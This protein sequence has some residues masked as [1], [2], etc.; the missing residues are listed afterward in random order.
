MKKHPSELTPDEIERIALEH[1][2]SPERIFYLSRRIDN[3]PQDLEPEIQKGSAMLRK[4]GKELLTRFYNEEVKR[5]EDVLKK[6]T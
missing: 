1:L 6:S 2:D 4:Q 3:D 5:R